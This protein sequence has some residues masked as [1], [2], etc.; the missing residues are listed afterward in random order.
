MLDAIGE[1]CRA[2]TLPKHL[3]YK[4]IKK[5]AYQTVYAWGT[6]EDDLKIKLPPS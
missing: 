4:E 1:M 5:A 6:A 2:S 3:F